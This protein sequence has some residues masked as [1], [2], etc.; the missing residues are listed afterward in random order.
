MSWKYRTIQ[1]VVR[2][3]GRMTFSCPHC[4]RPFV[5]NLSQDLMRREIDVKHVC[6]GCKKYI[7]ISIKQVTS[8]DGFSVIEVMSKNESLEALEKSRV[9]DDTGMVWEREKVC[10][11][12]IAGTGKKAQPM[13]EK[14]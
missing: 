9:T 11:I 10:L 12:R 2:I 7:L 8:W 4:R 1:M 14:G 5:L 3:S 13:G 6:S